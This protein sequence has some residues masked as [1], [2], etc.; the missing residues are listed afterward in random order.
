MNEKQRQAAGLCARCGAP[1]LPNDQRFCAEHREEY[2]RRHAADREEAKSEHNAW[3]RRRY[4]RRLANNECTKCGKPLADG[5]VRL[6]ADC[7]LATRKHQ[8]D[9]FVS[10]YGSA[11][12][13]RSVGDPPEQYTPTHWCQTCY[14]MGHVRPATGC[15]ECGKPYQAERMPQPIDFTAPKSSAG[16]W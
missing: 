11:K 7:R 4:E 1:R 6:C 10:H 16:G 15:P 12:R 13:P 2:R 3:H 8:R 5:V 14:G 9:Y